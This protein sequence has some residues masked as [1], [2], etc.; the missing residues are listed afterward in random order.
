[1]SRKRSPDREKALKLWLKSGRQMKPVQI[2][3]KLGVSAAIVRKWKSMDGWDKLP[4][5]KPGRALSA[6]TA[7]MGMVQ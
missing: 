2:A 1:M 7:A 5:P 6:Q 4:S 3:D